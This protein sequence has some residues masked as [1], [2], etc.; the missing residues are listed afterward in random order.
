LDLNAVTGLS[1]HVQVVMA[2]PTDLPFPEAA[3]DCAYAQNATM[4][5]ADKQ[6]LYAEAFRV[7][8]PGGV[9]AFA[10][11]S[12]GPRGE[13]YYPVPWAAEPTTSFLCPM[14]AIQTEVT[15]VGFELVWLH[16]R[17]KEIVADLRENRRRLETEGLSLLGLQ[18]LMGERIRELQIN[19]ARSTEEGRL[20]FIEA[21]ARKP[22]EPSARPALPTV[23]RG[24]AAKP[25]QPKVSDD[26]AIRPIT[27]AVADDEPVGR[28]VSVAVAAADKPVVEPDTIAHEE[29]AAEKRPTAR[30][31]AHL[32]GRRLAGEPAPPRSKIEGSCGAA[33]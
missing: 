27:V 6:R 20:T 7:L 22:V 13:P 1:S 23:R 12:A 14:S 31:K 33:D 25:Q 11:Y 9:L 15:A 28:P 26:E 18:T 21:L 29:A 24:M 10:L 16:D 2:C 5:I 17:T 8:R 19:V 32:A 30:R 4:N 3:F